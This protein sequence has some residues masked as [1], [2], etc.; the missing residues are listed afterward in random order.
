MRAAAA[1]VPETNLAGK[2]ENFSYF[3]VALYLQM[4]L[5]SSLESTEL[6]ILTSL[7]EDLEFQRGVM[8]FNLL[9]VRK[10]ILYNRPL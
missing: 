10:R 4:D 9:L 5:T 1:S 2:L 3:P 7:E 6:N 8:E